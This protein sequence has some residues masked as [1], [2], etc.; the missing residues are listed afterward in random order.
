M[1]PLVLDMVK[2]IFLSKVTN[3]AEN[4]L[5]T[6]AQASVAGT[7][8]AVQSLAILA[9]PFR[10]WIGACSSSDFETIS[11]APWPISPSW[12]LPIHYRKIFIWAWKKIL[13]VKYLEILQCGPIFRQFYKILRGLVGYQMLLRINWMPFLKSHHLSHMLLSFPSASSINLNRKIFLHHVT[14]TS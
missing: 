4:I 2:N 12:P 5:L 1:L 3:N 9:S 13:S 14:L 7:T 10:R 11:I 6:W 8:L